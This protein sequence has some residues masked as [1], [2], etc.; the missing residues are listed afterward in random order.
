[1]FAEKAFERFLYKILLLD[2]I[3]DDYALEF[4]NAS[5]KI[6]VGTILFVLGPSAFDRYH[7]TFMYVQW[8]DARL[9]GLLF[10]TVGGIHLY[11][12]FNKKKLLR[13]NSL[14]AAGILWLWFGSSIWFANKYAFN[15]Y[16]YFFFML[17]SF[18]C[19]LCIQ[20]FDRFRLHTTVG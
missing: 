7:E 3:K 9:W 1:M 15:P 12:L 16:I 20:V 8:M 5:I 2:W 6:V 18:R 4:Q 19:Y 11:G 17:S 10:M 13:K 14:L